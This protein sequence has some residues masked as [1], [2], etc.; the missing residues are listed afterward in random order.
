MLVSTAGV[1][2]DVDQRGKGEAQKYLEDF[3]DEK[4]G[5]GRRRLC[6]RK[7][8]GKKRKKTK[9]GGFSSVGAS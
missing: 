3:G 2:G 6:R 1:E 8:E 5:G 7:K 4:G 9:E